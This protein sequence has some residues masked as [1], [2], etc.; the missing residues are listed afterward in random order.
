[1]MHRPTL[2]TLLLVA[3]TA[4]CSSAT[5]GTGRAV[6]T[7]PAPPAGAG[8]SPPITQPVTSSS[9]AAVALP[10]PC[11]LVTHDEAEALAG[12]KLRGAERTPATD[13]ATDVAICQYNAPVTGPSGTVQVFVQMGTPRALKIDKAIHHRFVTLPGIAD[14]AL[15]EPDNASV[16]V[17]RGDVWV[18]VTVPYSATAAQLTSTARKIATRI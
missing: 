4:A 10:D 18:Y 12:V 15:E 17:R 6:S 1:M 2:S 8:A 14:E 3:A 16:F 11:S 13:P 9:S 5:A 7:T